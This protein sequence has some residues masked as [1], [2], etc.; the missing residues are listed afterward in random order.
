MIKQLVNSALA[1]LGLRV[2]RAEPRL[3]PWDYDFLAWIKE[4]KASGKDP[5]DVGDQD[6][7]DD[8]LKEALDRH[9]YPHMNAESVVMELGPGTGRATRYLIGRCREMILIDYSQ[10]V[11]DWLRE[12]LQGKG[13]FRV[14]QIDR[15]AVPE[16]ADGTVDLV[17]ANG[18]F[19]HI[20]ADGMMAFLQEFR[21]VL[22]PGGVVAFN[23]DTIMS[24]EG[25]RWFL[26]TPPQ[27]RSIFKFYHP[28]MVK[29]LAEAVGY[30]VIALST[31]ASRFA[32]IELRKPA[33][34]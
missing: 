14:Y 1:P 22:R 30:E 31:S 5:N 15:P 27:K 8:P 19:E 20:D 9:Y 13:K 3:K 17:V 28:D 18:V 6:W 29:K 33:N 16:V 12:Y 23:F 26:E 2:V 7:N 11:C 25:F 21:R 34:G 10:L 24:E 4:A 32:F